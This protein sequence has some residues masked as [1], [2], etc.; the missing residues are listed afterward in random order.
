MYALP[1]IALNALATTYG[2]A[3]TL[4]TPPA[5]SLIGEFDEAPPAP[6]LEDNI[7]PNDEAPPAAPA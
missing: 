3:G 5:A 7:E 6:P 2:E 4:D 1:V